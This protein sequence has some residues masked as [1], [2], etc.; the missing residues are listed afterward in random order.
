MGSV[1]H[2][3][4]PRAPSSISSTSAFNDH[5]APPPPLPPKPPPPGEIRVGLAKGGQAHTTRAGGSL[6]VSKIS[7]WRSRLMQLIKCRPALVN[8]NPTS[9]WTPSQTDGGVTSGIPVRP[10]G[11]AS[12]G[13]KGAVV[14]GENQMLTATGFMSRSPHQPSIEG[15]VSKPP[16]TLPPRDRPAASL[17]ERCHKDQAEKVAIDDLDDMTADELEEAVNKVGDLA[18]HNSV[19]RHLVDRLGE[20]PEG[21]DLVVEAGEEEE[22]TEE[23]PDL[24]TVDPVEDLSD[25][26]DECF[27]EGRTWHAVRQE[28]PRIPLVSNKYCLDRYG[29]ALCS[30]SQTHPMALMPTS[31]PFLFAPPPPQEASTRWRS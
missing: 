9:F 7:H 16:T 31:S 2:K 24:M 29:K 4:K 13:V 17:D 5:M 19:L 6:A 26:L 23:G 28:R 25:M 12:L 20:L 30:P 1:R 10:G 22:D 11:E 21:R 8:L 27:F 3:V 14:Q 15:A 18:K